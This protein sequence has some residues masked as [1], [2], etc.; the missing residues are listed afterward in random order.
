MNMHPKHGPLFPEAEAFVDSLRELRAIN[1]AVWFEREMLLAFERGH[2]QFIPTR[3]RR[4]V[5]LGRFWL[6]PVIDGGES[7]QSGDSLLLHYFFRPD[8]DKALHSHPWP[9]ETQVLRGNYLE[10]L[11]PLHWNP[12]SLLG[13]AYDERHVFMDTGHRGSH[14]TT[15]LHAVAEIAPGTV[16]IVRTGARV[17]TWYFHPPGEE[18]VH[19]RK[20]LD[21]HAKV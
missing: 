1:G 12:N 8:D 3:D 7:W 14:N 2:F 9:F 4:N 19:Y 21:T 20:F 6:T 18:K 5:Y 13:P 10:A 16:T 15:D 17:D 11:P